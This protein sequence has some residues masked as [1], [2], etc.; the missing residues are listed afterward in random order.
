MYIEKLS[1]INCRN[2]GNIELLPDKGFNILYGLNA[3]G[4]T[5]LLESVYL[6]ANLKS[7]RGSK[8][9]EIVKHD[10]NYCSINACVN[11]KGVKRNLK[12][13]IDKKIKKVKIDNKKPD[14][15]S[16][17]FGYLRPIL[18]SP[19]EVSLLKGYPSGRRSLLDRAVFQASPVFIN[20][21]MEYNR[22]LKQR[23][24]LLKEGK[25]LKGNDPWTEGLV[26][27]G[28]RVR[29]ERIKYLER[30]L[31]L[32]KEAFQR[33]TDGGERAD[34]IYPLPLAAENVL[35][36][37]FH[38]ELSRVEDREISF[39]QTLAGPHRDDPVFQINGKSVRHYGSQGQQRTFI[40]AF[41]TAQIM[42]LENILGE[43]P[44]LLLDDMTGELDTFRQNHFF[45][46]LKSRKGQVFITT[47]DIQP[48]LKAGI[49]DGRFF[50]VHQGSIQ[51]I[52]SNEELL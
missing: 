30:I 9:E 41:K 28:T 45:N 4:K 26:S 49:R 51:R 7:F 23:N 24:I 2:I 34:I 18:F 13:E 50:R 22:Y 19:E 14:S 35:K 46:F 47:T 12:L 42:D 3:Q 39:G 1:V 20:R 31:P 48:L 33:I 15:A 8:N 29:L 43:P 6:I 5:N 37:Q 16:E 38:Q 25:K 21:V 36:E 44:V 52:V 17:F 40:L 27:A 10:E 11:S 32:F